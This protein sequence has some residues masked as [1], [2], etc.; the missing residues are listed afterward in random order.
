[1]RPKLLVLEVWALGDLV[2]ATPFLQAAARE[3]DVTLLAKPMAKELQA[4][5][6]PGVEIIPFTLP[7]TAFRRKYALHAWPWSPL[8]NL[9]RQLRERRFDFAASARWDPRDHFLMRLSGAKHRIGF[10]RAGSRVF[11]SRDLPYLGLSAH[12]Y[13]S[14]RL[15]GQ[16][17]GLELPNQR[18]FAKTA[19]GNEIVIHTGSSH[20]VRVWPL[21][22]V[23]VIAKRLRQAG[24]SVRLLCDLNQAAWWQNQGEKVQVPGSIPELVAALKGAA[25]FIGNDSGPGHLAAALGI[26]TLTIFGS[27]IVSRFI[28]L[29]CESEAIEGKDC[30]FKPCS[31]SCHFEQPNCILEVGIEEVW[32]RLQSFIHKH[33][34]ST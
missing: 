19:S 16:S 6:W 12:R 1:M 4:H 24:E 20:P 22:R 15:L 8:F 25:V 32:A 2:I 33:K 23:L 5:L 28:P 11:L 9:L 7:W 13:D 26:P 30:P 31:D 18:A 10:S 29:N 17:I 21:D 34:V 3:Y 14:W 27:Q